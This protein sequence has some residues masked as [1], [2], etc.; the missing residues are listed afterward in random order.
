MEL[1][2]S[3]VEMSRD[4]RAEASSLGYAEAKETDKIGSLALVH[5]ARS[6]VG[7]RTDASN[8]VAK[9]IKQLSE[10]DFSTSPLSISNTGEMRLKQTK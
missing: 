9:E 7:P 2:F 10:A 5:L 4:P 6:R 1:N 8:R 3:S